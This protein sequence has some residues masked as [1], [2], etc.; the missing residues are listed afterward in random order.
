MNDHYKSKKLRDLITGIKVAVRR[1][2]DISSSESQKFIL[3]IFGIIGIPVENDLI[4]YFDK[5]SILKELLIDILSSSFLTEE[6]RKIIQEDFFEFLKLFP[7][8]K[9][10]KEIKFRILGNT[11]LYP[12]VDIKRDKIW[13][14]NF[15]SR[16]SLITISSFNSEKKYSNDS[17]LYWISR[18]ELKFATSMI[19]SE[20]GIRL[21][22]YFNPYD[23]IS[24]KYEDLK[25]VP[26][27]KL[28]S[29]LNKWMDIKNV[30]IQPD[31][32]MFNRHPRPDISTF[33]YYSFDP[34]KSG[35]N[36]IFDA[37]SIQDHL[38][39]RTSNYLLKALM[40]RDNL[41]FQEEALV[42][43]FFALE[44]SLHL[45]QRKYGD[46]STKLNRKLLR[47]I[48]K[49]KLTF[50]PNGEGTYEFIEEG[51][52]TR[53]SLVHPEP[54]WGAEWNPYVHIEDFRDY[55]GISKMILAWTLGEN[56]IDFW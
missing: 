25:N 48:F 39:M 21:F 19:L 23:T 28:F 51:Y 50:L 24:L 26:E 44:G 1:N 47:E 7:V 37:Y 32:D 5:P 10:R 52:F 9:S 31:G 35:F 2:K 45:L 13:Y 38:M 34:N 56:K 27:D 3:G 8:S 11:G 29:V 33:N 12:N 42:N 22:P 14:K 53:I 36:K 17:W 20:S 18:T 4:T 49:N 16:P 40:N 6:D 55:F 15:N 46:Y 54:K 43:A 30:F 41:L